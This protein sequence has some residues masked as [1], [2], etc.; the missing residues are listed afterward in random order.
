ML[1]RSPAGSTIRTIGH[2][3]NSPSNRYNPAPD[4]PVYWS[5]QSWDEMFNG[6]MELSVDKDVLN[7]PKAT[8][9]QQQQ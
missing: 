9:Q 7:A 8:T 1:F 6:W 3:D 4:K 5:E 2:Y